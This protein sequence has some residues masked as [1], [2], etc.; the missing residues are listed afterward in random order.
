MAVRFQR[1][2]RAKCSTW[3]IRL[4][5]RTK[6]DDWLPPLLEEYAE[7]LNGQSESGYSDS[8][9]IW[10]AIMSPILPEPASAP[11]KGVV[12]PPKLERVQ[13]AYNALMTESD[14]ARA[15]IV[16]R[17]YYCHAVRVDPETGRTYRQESIAKTVCAELNL[18]R[19]AMFDY[20]RMG[21][22]AIRGYIKAL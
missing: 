10:R 16:T 2:V 18:R 21:E 8:T 3:N 6:R 1:S 20:K 19:T 11:P 4:N 14:A 17:T 12:P 9:T 5:V 22:M 15:V 7:W 13:R